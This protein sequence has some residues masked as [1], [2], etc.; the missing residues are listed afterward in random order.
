MYLDTF[1]RGSYDTPL[2]SLISLNARQLSVWGG[3]MQLLQEDLNAILSPKMRIVV[4]G[5]T[6]RSAR[7]AAEDLQNSGVPCE[8]RDDAKTLSLGRVTVLPGSLSA[9]FEYPTANFALITHGHFAAAPKR[10]RKRQKNAKE[11]YSLSEL[12]PGDYIVHS[13]HGVGV[14]EGIHKLEMQGV[15]KDYLK[16]RYAKGDILYVPVTQLDMVSK[17]IGPKEEV[18]VRLNRLGG[19]DWQKAKARVRSAV[20]DIAKELIKL[21]AERMKAEGP[22]LPAGYRAGSGILRPGSSTRKRRTSSGAS[23]EIKEDMETEQPHGP[24]AVRRRGLRQNRGGPAGGL[25]MRHGRQAVRL[26]GAHHHSGLAALPDR[27]ASGSRASP[28]RWRSFPGSARPSSR[29]RFSS[30]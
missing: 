29:R 7:A 1:V 22:R 4:L 28:S 27:Y 5:G 3:G 13:A 16:V 15:T 12:A 23:Q 2:S 19:Q 18:K 10:T 9:G 14:F 20:K 6:E 25:Q 21:Y 24:A 11:I 30:S 17:Y 8:Y 26:A